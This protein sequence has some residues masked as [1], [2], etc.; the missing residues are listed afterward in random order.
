MQ[1]ASLPPA[2]AAADTAANAVELRTAGAVDTSVAAADTAANR[3][4]L[5]LVLLIP[6]SLLLI[7]LLIP[8][9]LLLLMLLNYSWCC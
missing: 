2:V 6:L 7:L 5:Q 1:S 3:V 8:L 4:E 9:S